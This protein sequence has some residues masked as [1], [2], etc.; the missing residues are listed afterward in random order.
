[1]PTTFPE[2]EVQVLLRYLPL[3]GGLREKLQ[4]VRSELTRTRVGDILTPDKFTPIGEPLTFSQ[5]LKQ[6]RTIEIN[7]ARSHFLAVLKTAPLGEQDKPQAITD[8]DAITDHL[9]RHD[10][11]EDA[12]NGLLDAL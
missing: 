2:N 10:L 11:G 3:P 4:R 1:M 12:I 7:N 9:L 8:L 5:R 6:N